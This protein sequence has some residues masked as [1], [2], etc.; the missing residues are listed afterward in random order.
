MIRGGK[1]VWNII[2]SIDTQRRKASKASGGTQ[3]L[4]DVSPRLKQIRT[5]S[6]AIRAKQSKS[7]MVGDDVLTWNNKDMASRL[8]KEVEAEE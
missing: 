6:L 4:E 2:Q 7:N 5:G 8:L 3:K 1:L